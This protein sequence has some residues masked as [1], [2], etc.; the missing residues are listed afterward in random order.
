MIV[1]IG[2]G[3]GENVELHNVACNESMGQRELGGAD[4]VVGKQNVE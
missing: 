2:G 4:G 1:R 3:G